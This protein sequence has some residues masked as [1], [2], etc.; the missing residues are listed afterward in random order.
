MP[1]LVAQCSCPD[2]ETA[3][4]IARQLVD[5]H[6][7][8]CVQTIPGV[9]STYRWQGALHTDSEVLLV[10]KTTRARFDALK[11][12]LPELHPYELPEL[13]ALDV[14]DGLDRYLHWVE[15]ETQ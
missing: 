14:V 6:L 3:T 15:S 4:R 1:V 10:I 11:S 2:A 12:R 5:E 7:A 13:I 9:G 8:A